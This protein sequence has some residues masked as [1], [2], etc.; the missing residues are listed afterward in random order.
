MWREGEGVRIEITSP[1]VD[2]NSQCPKDVLKFTCGITSDTREK[3]QQHRG[4]AV[5]NEDTPTGYNHR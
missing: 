2:E 3:G 4:D 1:L 5:A